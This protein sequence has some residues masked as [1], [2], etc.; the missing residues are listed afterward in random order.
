MEG[1]TDG[2]GGGLGA[3]ST[4]TIN[5]TQHPSTTTVVSADPN[6]SDQTQSIPVFFTVASGGPA[7][8][9]TVT[10]T[11]SGGTESCT[12]PVGDG[13]CTLTPTV[14]GPRNIIATYAG[15]A[16]TAGS[17]SA[18]LAHTVNACTVDPIVTSHRRQRRRHAA[19]RHRR[20]LL[21]QH[22]HLQHPRSGTA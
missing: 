14:A 10:V 9:G 3:A 13:Q 7:P 17:V 11:I 19:R 8:T 16:L 22:R 20:R 1:A 6:P 2:V 15:D 5:V 4:A 18:P 21:R 12:A